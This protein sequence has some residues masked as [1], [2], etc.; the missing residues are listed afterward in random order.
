M[1][2]NG[3]K[4]FKS[5]PHQPTTNGLADSELCP[6]NNKSNSSNA[7]YEQAFEISH[8]PPKTQ[9]AEGSA[10]QAY[11]HIAHWGSKEFWCWT[12]SSGTWL[13]RKQVD[14][15]T[16]RYKKW[17]TAVRGGCW[18]A[19]METS[20][21]SVTE[22]AAKQHLWAACTQPTRFNTR[23]PTRPIAQSYSRH[24]KNHDTCK[25][26]CV[27]REDATGSMVLPRKKQGTT[28]KTGVVMN[29]LIYRW[30]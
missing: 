24:S 21:R 8:W 9:L 17:A 28:Q 23:L 29:C 10:E 27:S 11:Q 4:H 5:A 2:M 18:R 30:L 3:I 16:D 26:K 13:L 14:T 25:E 6:F 1:K 15:R 19:D 7:V 12:T 20:C 22:C